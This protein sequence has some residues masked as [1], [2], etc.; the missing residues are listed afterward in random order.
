MKMVIVTFDE[1][2]HIFNDILEAY[3]GI[4]QPVQ[5]QNRTA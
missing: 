2:V 4:A 3:I 5:Q 1:P